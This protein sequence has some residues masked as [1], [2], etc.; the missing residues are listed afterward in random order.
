MIRRPM[1]GEALESLSQSQFPIMV[2]PKIDGFRCILDQHP[3]T[4]RLSPFPNVDFH[5]M[6]EHVLP[7]GS[8]LDSEVVV[9]A[10]RGKGVLQRTSSGL[11]SQSGSPNFTLWVFDHIPTNLNMPFQLR[12]DQAE[13]IV[14]ELNHPRVKL[15][16]YRW[17]NSVQQLEALLDRA[18]RLEYEGIIGRHPEAPYKEGKATVRQGYMW[19][20]KPFETAEGRVKGWYE[21]EKN[22]N[23][24]KREITGKLRRSSAKAGKTL[25][26][27][28]GGLILEDCKTKVEV[29]VGGGYTLR[30]RQALWA[31]IQHDPDSLKGQLT[32]YKKQT[33]GEKDK[34]RHPNFVEFIDFR[35]EW[36]LTD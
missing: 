28:L 31:L 12:Y 32:R 17:A 8:T 19:K 21:E 30:Q 9:G 20:V 33:V 11:T 7:V 1:K 10:R 25:K 36:D 35:P 22:N 26:G 34:P 23:V 24:A 5:T 14:N 16:K 15:L 18:L 2:F 27:Q 29:R 6:M 13:F 4:S 3:L